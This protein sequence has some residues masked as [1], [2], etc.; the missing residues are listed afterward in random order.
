VAWDVAR[1]WPGAELHIVDGVGH[2][3]S[4]RMNALMV[5]ATDRFAPL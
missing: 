4:D 1:R 3:G 5:A 2:L